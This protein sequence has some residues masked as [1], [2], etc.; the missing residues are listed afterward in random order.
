MSTHN[1]YFLWNSKKKSRNYHQFRQIH[2]LLKKSSAGVCNTFWQYFPLSNSE[3]D[4]EVWYYSTPGQIVEV[5]EV[6][7]KEGYERDLFYMM[8][9]TKEDILRQMTITEELT[10]SHSNN[11]KSAIEIEKGN[12]FLR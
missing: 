11:K 6:I 4:N 9:D 5:L 1:I 8:R 7:D 2:V 3:G 12:T 10:N